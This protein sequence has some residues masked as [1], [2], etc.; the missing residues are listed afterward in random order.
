MQANW[1][2]RTMRRLTAWLKPF[3]GLRDGLL[4][5]GAGLYGI[6]YLVWSIR[7]WWEGLGLLPVL[8]AQYFV[9]GATVATAILV[10]LGVV[11]IPW[12]VRARVHSWLSKPTEPRPTIRWLVAL[13]LYLSVIALIVWAWMYL[14]AERWLGVSSPIQP[15]F[16]YGAIA[17]VAILGFFS[18]EVEE[19]PR[20]L[21]AVPWLA[22]RSQAAADE[23]FA[24]T[25]RSSGIEGPGQPLRLQRFRQGLLRPPFL[26]GLAYIVATY[27][28]VLAAIC[29]LPAGFLAF[30]NLPQEFGGAHPSCV[31]LDIDRTMMA[32]ETQEA[33]LPE[34]GV[35]NLKIAR[36]IRL[37]LLFAGGDS[38]SVRRWQ[39]DRRSAGDPR[40]YAIGSK[41][42]AST[43]NCE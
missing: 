5:L 22:V 19:P 17:A 41:L 36:T 24:E 7:A 33:L 12:R 37:A 18:A 6:G 42:V 23:R 39:E 21:A 2:F 26:G 32:K 25:F 31:Q 10:A 38:I 4:V 28:S 8:S 16:F 30:M 20:W 34:Q 43:V 11:L 9:A 14:V 13:T 40:V 35:S 1:L 29:C 15:A 27:L 3:A